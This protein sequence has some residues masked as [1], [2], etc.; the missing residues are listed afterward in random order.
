LDDE[1]AHALVFGKKTKSIR[2]KMAKQCE[3][4]IPPVIESPLFDDGE[5]TT[6]SE[7]TN[8]P[9]QEPTSAGSRSWFLVGAL[10]ILLLVIV[11]LAVLRH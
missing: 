5:A 1:P 8:V 2:T 10:L 7:T 9:P 4:V 3:W 11:L 6:A